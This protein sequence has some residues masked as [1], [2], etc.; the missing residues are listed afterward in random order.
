MSDL[1]GTLTGPIVHLPTK[2]G[3]LSVICL[4]VVVIQSLLSLFFFFY[5]HLYR[6]GLLQ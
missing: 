4:F 6:L 1:C 2:T 3:T 5:T